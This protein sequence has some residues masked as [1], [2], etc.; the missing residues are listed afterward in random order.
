MLFEEYLFKYKNQFFGKN[1]SLNNNKIK[2]L[3]KKN[4]S[5]NYKFYNFDKFKKDNKDF[6]YNYLKHLKVNKPFL[7]IEYKNKSLS[8]LSI[9]LTIYLSK[10]IKLKNKVPR[11]N[12]NNEFMNKI[13]NRIKVILKPFKYWT[14]FLKI[15][16]ENNLNFHFFNNNDY[17]YK[18]L[19]KKINR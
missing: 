8:D 12:N 17:Y 13:I 18:Q 19:I 1:R 11:S 16:V 10:Y 5:Q 14:T 3:I 2:N 6:I 7:E 9:K 4:F 15:V